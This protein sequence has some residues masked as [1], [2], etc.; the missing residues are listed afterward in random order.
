MASRVAVR[1]STTKEID[2]RML[3]GKVTIGLFAGIFDEEGRL[4]LRRRR[5]EEPT[6][7]CLYEGDWELP[8]GTVE[9]ENILCSEDV[10]ILGKE[11]A[12]EVMEETGLSIKLPF[13]FVLH[14]E[15][16][17][18]RQNRIIDL[19]F[20]VPIGTTKKRPVKGEHAYVNPKGLKELSE[21]PEGNRLVSGWGKRMCR[22]AMFALCHSPKPQYRREA[23][24]MLLRIK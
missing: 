6:R 5:R 18:D 11:L 1:K 2:K 9:E 15:I 8:G 13:M 7:P 20:V 21:R 19:A 24:N 23:R 10:D 14:P 22:M 4:L 17:V 12:R 16:Y 3:C